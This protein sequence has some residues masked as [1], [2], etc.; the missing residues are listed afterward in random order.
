MRSVY[1]SRKTRRKAT[2]RRR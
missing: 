1:G 2:R